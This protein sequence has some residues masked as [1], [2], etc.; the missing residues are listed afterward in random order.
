MDTIMIMN[1]PVI[2]VQP[3][4]ANITSGIVD[5]AEVRNYNVQFT[6]TGSP[7]GTYNVLISNDGVNFGPVGAAQA[8]NTAGT[9]NITDKAIGYR[10]IEVI[11]SFTSG[12]GILSASVCGK[13]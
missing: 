13:Q 5:L 9:Q 2:T 1:K 11:F 8:I 6:A 7:I 10:Y 12:S 3:M 4:T